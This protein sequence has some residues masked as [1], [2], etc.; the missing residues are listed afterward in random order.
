MRILVL[1]TEAF[2]GHGGIAQYNKHLLAALST[3]PDCTE[4]VAIPRLMS[5]P[6]EPLPTKVTY[7]TEGLN[8]KL[9]YIWVVL[10]VVRRNPQFNLIICGHIHLL[11]IAYLL[12][13]W[14]QLPI[15]LVIYGIDAW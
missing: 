7:V 6:R 11:P 1:T 9:K 8:S 13:L 10:R 4:V 2:G 12:H 5:S 15:L 3:Y 14:I